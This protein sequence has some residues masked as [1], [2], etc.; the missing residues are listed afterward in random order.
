MQQTR[1]L[2]N[3][4]TENAERILNTKTFTQA[5][6]PRG[7]KVSENPPDSRAMRAFYGVSERADGKPVSVAPV[8]KQ[9][10]YLG[11]MGFG[12]QTKV[13]ETKKAS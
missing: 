5:A 10:S 12:M 9:E 8:K 11:Q 6:N 2:R 3:R 1:L 4:L 7:S 13:A